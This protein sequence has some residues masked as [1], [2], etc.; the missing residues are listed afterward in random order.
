MTKTKAPKNNWI[1][2]SVL[3]FRNTDDS[4]IPKSK[5]DG[6]YL[7]LVNL[8]IPLIPL[9][10]LFPTLWPTIWGLGGHKKSSRF[11]IWSEL[12]RKL[13]K[14]HL[15]HPAPLP[16]PLEEGQ[17]G[18]QKIFTQNHFHQNISTNKFSPKK[19]SPKKFHQQNFHQKKI[20]PKKFSAKKFYPNNFHPK[21]FSP[22]KFSAKKFFSQKISPKKIHP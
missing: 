15:R 20:S 22:K 9:T 16:P 13:V 11:G 2:N 8:L 19:T 17:E 7:P 3:Y 6:G 4:S 12:A 5:Y 10:P 18:E 14:S 1:T 21:K